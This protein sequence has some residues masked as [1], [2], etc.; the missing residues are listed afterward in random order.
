[1]VE[2]DE[3]I[4]PASVEHDVMQIDAVDDDVGIFEAGAQRR[5]GW[6]P[7]DLLAVECVDHQR[8]GWR[9]GLFQHGIAHADAIERMKDIRPELDAIAD[10]AEGRRAFEHADRLPLARERERGGQPAK[11][12]TDDEDRGRQDYTA[13]GFSFSAAS[14]WLTAGRAATW[15]HRTSVSCPQTRLEAFASQS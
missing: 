6:H 1:G 4:A 5:S 7:R 3:R 8:G 2:R 10:S 9:I 14:E 12:A 15:K 13:L 11:P